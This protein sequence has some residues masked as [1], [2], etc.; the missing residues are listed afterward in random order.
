MLRAKH[1]ICYEPTVCV[2]YVCHDRV[3][4]LRPACAIAT[5]KMPMRPFCSTTATCSPPRESRQPSCS[6]RLTGRAAAE[7]RASSASPCAVGGSERAPCESRSRKSGGL[8]I[9]AATLRRSATAAEGS[10]GQQ[11]RRAVH[12]RAHRLALH[13]IVLS[14][15]LAELDNVAVGTVA[16]GLRIEP[17][18]AEDEEVGEPTGHRARR[19]GEQP[20][21]HVHHHLGEHDKEPD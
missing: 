15:Q 7:G 1:H 4:P 3:C 14:V 17:R 13:V 8:A 18:P 20:L 6:K 16:E 11:R 2:Y 21:P 12:R 9:G 10:K 19:D 5:V